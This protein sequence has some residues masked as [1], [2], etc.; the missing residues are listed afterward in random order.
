VANY[1]H[2]YVLVSRVGNRLWMPSP[3]GLNIYGDFFSLGFFFVSN[4]L[5]IKDE[6]PSACGA[7]LALQVNPPWRGAG[8]QVSPGSLLLGSVLQEM[9]VASHL[10]FL[11]VLFECSVQLLQRECVLGDDLLFARA[12][13]LDRVQF[14]QCV[15]LLGRF[16]Q[17]LQ[18]RA[19]LPLPRLVAVR[20]GN[21]LDLQQPE[22]FV[23]THVTNL[24][25][26][27]YRPLLCLGCRVLASP[28][29]PEPRRTA[30]RHSVL[31]FVEH[32]GTW[33]VFLM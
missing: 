12:P 9:V 22:P 24:H 13:G 32:L 6:Q 14:L 18:R 30:T 4:P 15:V 5:D 23:G 7:V 31:F 2:Q 10:E 8:R 17:F 19:E 20:E 11:P 1:V 28:K 21:K 33:I 26:C 29:V 16:V 27:T 25:Q 3:D